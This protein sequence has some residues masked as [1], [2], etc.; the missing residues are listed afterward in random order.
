M[1]NLAELKTK[2]KD[3][4]WRLNNLYWIKN[5]HGEKVKFRLNRVQNQLIEE[6]HTLNI[7]L[8]ARQLGMT[9]FI[10]ILMLDA[11]LFNSNYKCGVIAHNRDDAS[12]FFRNKI[13]FAYD[14]LPSFIKSYRPATQDSASE[15]AFNNDSSIRVGTSLRSGTYQIL[16]ISEF[17]KLC[18]QYPD[19]AQEVK[20]GAL[21][22]VHSGNYV[23]IESTAEGDSGEFYDMYKEYER[24][25]NHTDMDYKC[26]FYPWYE[27]PSYRLAE[28]VPISDELSDY[29]DGL[30]VHLDQEQKNWYS[31]KKR[32][33]KNK[34][35]Q[36]FPSTP[37]EA[38]AQIGEYCVYGDE[39]GVV[40]D[41]GR[42][43]NLPKT[44]VP[45]DLF[46]DIGA[47]KKH[48]T[49][50]I[51]FMQ[52]NEPWHDFVDYYQCALKSI[53][54]MVDDIKS[55]GWNINRWYV[56][57]DSTREDHSLMTYQDRLVEAG[58]AK[59]SIVT[60]PRVDRVRTG[61]DAMRN[62]FAKCR[63]DK[64][65][66]ELGWK[67]LKAYRYDWDAKMGVLGS[68]RHDWAS[69]PSDAIRQYAQAY[70][71]MTGSASFN[72]SV[73]AGGFSVY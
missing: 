11:C 46:F 27:E 10:Q 41:E 70:R 18:A 1:S 34:M 22:T 49:T 48:E 35:Q 13:K 72:E 57:H 20:T 8:K 55:M 63:F 40:I 28:S 65:R 15:L 53:S 42:L 9:T 56:P 19:R 31:A 44:K 6:M 43:L 38:F 68:P 25:V 5:I 33:Q 17:G 67:A 47:S 66:V 36:E 50:C 52:D 32:T 64:T 3:K 61:I 59:S 26:H 73:Q 24:V 29:L 37:D 45:V 4:I 2:I 23:F 30:G 51:W 58:V 21:N 14:N 62:K 39:I 54:D 16:H 7:I 12:D 71:P 69:H 60:V